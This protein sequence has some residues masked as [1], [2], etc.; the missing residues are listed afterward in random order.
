MLKV[1]F[2]DVNMK[3]K[4]TVIGKVADGFFSMS[5]KGNV[6]FLIHVDLSALK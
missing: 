4:N 2:A 1:W 6:M 3:T 5:G